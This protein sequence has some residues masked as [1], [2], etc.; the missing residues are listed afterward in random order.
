MCYLKEIVKIRSNNDMYYLFFY[1]I[2]QKLIFS[3]NTTI[4]FN[5]NNI[6]F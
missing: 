3:L 2:K 5:K 6:T 4:S 1:N